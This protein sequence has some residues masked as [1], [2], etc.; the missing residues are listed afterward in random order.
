LTSIEALNYEL[1]SDEEPLTKR[2]QKICCIKSGGMFCRLCQENMQS[3]LLFTSFIQKDWG[4]HRM[5]I[6]PALSINPKGK[7]THQFQ[8]LSF[9][10]HTQL[11][12]TGICC[13]FSHNSLP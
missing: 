2:D 12:V 3:L 11:C 1:E 9:V 10:G 5:L 6:T 4:N 7:A 8:G 13:V